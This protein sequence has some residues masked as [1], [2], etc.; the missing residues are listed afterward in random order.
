MDLHRLSRIFKKIILFLTGLTGPP[1][2]GIPGPSSYYPL[3]KFKKSVKKPKLNFHYG[4]YH[5]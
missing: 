3:I 2:P 5:A 1:N 4:K